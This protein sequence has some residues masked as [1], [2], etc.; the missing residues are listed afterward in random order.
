MKDTSLSEM[1]KVM[2]AVSDLMDFGD[3]G[4]VFEYLSVVGN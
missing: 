2:P 4:E 1:S 3:P